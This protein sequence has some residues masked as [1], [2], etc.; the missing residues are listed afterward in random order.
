MIDTR[1]LADPEFFSRLE[2]VELRARA[3]AAPLQRPARGAR[4]GVSVMRHLSALAL[5][6]AGL[7]SLS[8]AAPDEDRSREEAAE[9]DR[10]CAAELPRW[11]LTADGTALDTPKGSVLRWTNPFA[12]RVYGNTYVWLQEGRPAAAGCMFRYFDPYRSFNGELTALTGAKLVA[13]RDDTVV[14]RPK[15]EWK[16]HPVPGAAAPAATAAMRLVQMRGLAAD[17]VV[18]VLDT[19]NLRKGE[20]QT[21]R[22]LPRPL[23]RYDAEQT[24]T[25]DGALYAFVLGTDPELLLLLEC[26]T[27]AE[28]PG[29][30]FGVGRM[31]RDQIRLKRKGETVWEVPALREFG[32]EDA[33]RFLDIGLPREEPKP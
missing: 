19:R 3:V 2:S 12:G 15:D 10:L 31:N 11:H 24:R 4:E 28:K 21:P 1:E 33:Y 13:K 23:Y 27:A 18:E 22:L 25:L 29:W 26:N 32:N 14:W 7:A 30:R 5:L 9:A 8:A 6:G 17:F 16:W 20:D